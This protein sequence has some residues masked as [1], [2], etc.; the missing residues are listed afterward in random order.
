M[1][2]LLLFIVA[3]LLSGCGS[4]DAQRYRD[5]SGDVYS[6]RTAV[7]PGGSTHELSGKASWYGPGFQGNK[8]ANGETFDARKLTA[9]HKTL[10]F[11]TWIRVVDPV[12]EK[13]VVVRVN[14]RGP[15]KRGRVVDLSE[16]AAEDLDMKSRG[17]IEVELVILEWGE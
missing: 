11:G 12:T 14:D 4:G 2:G 3:A 16:A 8:T 10:P 6:G 17:I 1:R 9:A 5:T 13:S 7:D 15:F